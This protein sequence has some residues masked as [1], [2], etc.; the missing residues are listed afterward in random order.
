MF[1][2]LVQYWITSIASIQG[3]TIR[4]LPNKK[5]GFWL[6]FFH[7]STNKN[8]KSCCNCKCSATK[9][10]VNSE[11]KGEVS[12]LAL[13][14]EVQAQELIDDIMASDYMQVDADEMATPVE[15]PKEFWRIE[16]C[17]IGISRT[18]FADILRNQN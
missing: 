12:I 10:A 15:T 7:D 1:S 9:E 8:Q 3:I 4:Q 6:I 14:E 5:L 2:F 13:E 18:L 16:S 11:A 17:M